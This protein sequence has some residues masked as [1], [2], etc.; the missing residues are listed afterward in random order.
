M[1][2]TFLSCLGLGLVSVVNGIIL[3][4]S[5]GTE[6]FADAIGNPRN[7][8]IVF[9]HGIT[10]SALVW[11]DLF[12]DKRLLDHFYL[13]SYDLRGHGRSGKPNTTEAYVSNLFADDFAAVIKAFKV[14]S[15]LFVGWYWTVTSD[16]FAHLP[17]RTI[18]GIVA[19]A[20]TPS[21]GLAINAP[22]TIALLPGFSVTNDVAVDISTKS[23]FID[24]CFNDPSNVAIDIIWSWLASSVIQLPPITGLVGG[25]PQDTTKLFEAGAKGFPYLVI[26]GT[27]DKIALNDNVT[28]EIEPHFTNL[29]VIRIQGGAHAVFIENEDEFVRALVPFANKILVL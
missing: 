7:P 29:E 17:P 8:P 20:A 13:V 23:T 3:Q 1:K 9:V 27:E 14:K 19:V 5:D 11:K 4:S 28:A 15:P 16:I 24:A 21:T 25:R 26:S 18:S 6:I 10:L 22:T 12:Q 2:L